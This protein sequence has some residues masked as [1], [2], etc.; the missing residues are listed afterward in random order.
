MVHAE[1]GPS[2]GMNVATVGKM[3]EDGT[4]G[5]GNLVFF[6]RLRPPAQGDM[7]PDQNGVPADIVIR[8]NYDDRCSALNSLDRGR[9]T[10]RPRPDDH[11][12]RLKV[13]SLSIVRCCLCHC[14]VL[15]R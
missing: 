2:W 12:I 4:R 14:P 8:F 3:E 9:K 6:L 5:V 1:S 11:N 7:A 10:R 15:Q 13:P